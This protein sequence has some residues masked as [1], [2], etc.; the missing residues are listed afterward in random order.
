MVGRVEYFRASPHSFDLKG[1]LDAAVDR[2]TFSSIIP[3][4]RGNAISTVESSST[5]T[6]E[7]VA[8]MAPSLV[9]AVGE[10][11]SRPLLPCFWST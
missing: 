11:W 6:R 9:A 3:W 8:A 10:T 5:E 2:V 1:I 4:S 7:S